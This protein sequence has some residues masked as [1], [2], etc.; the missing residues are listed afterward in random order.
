LRA[1]TA[2]GTAAGLLSAERVLPQLRAIYVVSAGFG[3]R[4]GGGLPDILEPALTPRHRDALHS[5]AAGVAAG[6]TMVAGWRERLLNAAT[7]AD[8]RAAAAPEGSW[9]RLSEQVKSILWAALAGL[10]VGLAAG[11]LSHLALDAF[12]ASSIPFIIAGF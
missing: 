4:V 6:A 10:L 8:A 12:T 7:E 9:E 3:G 1:G 11:Y 2:A 5:V